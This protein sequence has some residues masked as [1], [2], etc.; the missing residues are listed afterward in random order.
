MITPAIVMM[1]CG[2]DGK[3][4]RWCYAILAV[5]F[6]LFQA[7]RVW[8]YY[9]SRTDLTGAE[10]PPQMINLLWT[11]GHTYSCGIAACIAYSAKSLGETP[12]K[13]LYSVDAMA[14]LTFVGILITGNG[15]D[16]KRW[17]AHDY[18]ALNQFLILYSQ[19]M[20]AASC[21]WMAFRCCSGHL[22]RVNG[23]LSMPAWVPLA[24]LSYAAHLLQFV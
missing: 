2:R 5:V 4:R 7:T 22:P 19:G 20:V 6:A 13:W 11:R 8:V 15:M 23:L 21:A 24:R 18:P 9:T 3:P 16:P 12:S 1:A 17:V 14:A 10:A